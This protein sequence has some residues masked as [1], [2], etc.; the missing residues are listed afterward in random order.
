M[1]LGPIH[2]QSWRSG[3]KVV[4]FLLFLPEGGVVW[5]AVCCLLLAA[6]AAAARRGGGAIELQ[7]KNCHH[8]LSRSVTMKR[9]T[10]ELRTGVADVAHNARL[11]RC[12]FRIFTRTHWNDQFA[13]DHFLSGISRPAFLLALF[14]RLIRCGIHR[15]LFAHLLLFYRIFRG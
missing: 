15:F 7:K 1:K 10:R 5:L 9:L 14:L 3:K 12:L 2:S 8:L 6:A 13:R 11:I 4:V